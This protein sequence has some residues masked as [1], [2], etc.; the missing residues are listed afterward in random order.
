MDNPTNTTSKPERHESLWALIV[1]PIIWAVHFLATYLTA[2]I[3]CA[4]FAESDRSFDEV[5]L[6]VG[7]FTVIALVGISANGLS[8]YRHHTFGD[9]PLPHDDDTPEDRHRFLGFATLL[10]AGLSA[11]AT[12]FVAAVAVFVRS[13]N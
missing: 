1:S 2:A 3:W 12:L 5:R 10:L 13:C 7:I 11:V 9:E 8:G 6:A 4:K